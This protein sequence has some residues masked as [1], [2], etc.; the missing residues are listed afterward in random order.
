[1]KGVI[2]AEVMTDRYSPR[3]SLAAIGL[4]LQS[5]DLFGPI[6]ELVKIPQK[7]IKHSPIDK[8]QDAFI[9]FWPELREL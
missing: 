4:K 7:T 6:R 3:A 5:I 2:D 8:L 9:T 1:M